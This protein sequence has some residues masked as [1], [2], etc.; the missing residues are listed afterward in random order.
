VAGDMG[1]LPDLQDRA[2]RI[3]QA[4]VL[5]DVHF[6]EIAG[7]RQFTPRILSLEE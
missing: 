6:P 4:L 2:G 1:K 7:L 5:E 3:G